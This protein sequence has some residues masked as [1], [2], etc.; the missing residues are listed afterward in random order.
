MFTHA[1]VGYFFY[2]GNMLPGIPMIQKAAILVVLDR[3]CLQ[4]LLDEQEVHIDGGR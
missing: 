3:D 4:R 1:S 2:H